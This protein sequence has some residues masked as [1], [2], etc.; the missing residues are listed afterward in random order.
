[1][2]I[3]ETLS[4]ITSFIEICILCIDEKGNIKRR[5]VNSKKDFNIIGVKS[6]YEIFSKEENRRI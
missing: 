5:V 4:I 1:M 3:E 6:I 2:N